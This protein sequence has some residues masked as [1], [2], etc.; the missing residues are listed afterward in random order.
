M[1][2]MNGMSALKYEKRFEII[3]NERNDCHERNEQLEI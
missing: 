1:I 2:D 3:Q